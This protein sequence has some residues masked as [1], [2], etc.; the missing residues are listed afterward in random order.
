MRQQLRA[1]TMSIPDGEDGVLTVSCDVAKEIRSPI[2]CK[3]VE[4][5]L[6]TKQTLTDFAGV[7]ELIEWYRAAIG[8]L[9]LLKRAQECWH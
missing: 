3:K 1:R 5:H 7:V 6:M 9:N 2:G 4:L 8:K